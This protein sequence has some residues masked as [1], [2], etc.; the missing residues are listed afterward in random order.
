MPRTIRTERCRKMR[1]DVG[2]CHIEVERVQVPEDLLPH[3]FQLRRFTEFLQLIQ[4]FKQ[5]TH[6]RLNLS[7]SQSSHPTSSKIPLS[8]FMVTGHPTEN[9]KSI[10]FS[11]SIRLL[12]RHP[13]FTSYEKL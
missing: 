11:P 10:F 2:N 1:P 4:H 13:L 8:V 9:V 5:C 12:V 7:R 3:S 6:P